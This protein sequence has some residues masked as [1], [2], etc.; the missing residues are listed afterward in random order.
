MPG[1]A[2]RR[3]SVVVRCLVPFDVAASGPGRRDGDAGLDGDLD[4]VGS[5]SQPH[6]TSHQQPGGFWRLIPPRHSCWTLVSEGP[7]Q[8]QLAF[9]GSAGA[10][11]FQCCSYAPTVDQRGADRALL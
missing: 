1:S 2:G 5:D 6:C 8:V 10:S 11:D 3:S 7:G 4:G 9:R